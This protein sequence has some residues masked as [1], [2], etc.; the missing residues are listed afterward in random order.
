[1]CL[2][3][4]TAGTGGVAQ[5]VDHLP[6]KSKVLSSNPSNSVDVLSL[7]TSWFDLENPPKSDLN[8]ISWPYPTHSKLPHWI[9]HI[10]LNLEAPSVTLW[11]FF[12]PLE[13]LP[14]FTLPTRELL[15]TLQ[16]PVP[17]P[18]PQGLSRSFLVK[19]ISSARQPQQVVSLSRITYTTLNCNASIYLPTSW[20]MKLI[21]NIY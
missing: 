9:Y 21:I 1:V 3:N 6:S 5:M 2:N 20:Q 8:S 11:V 14:L 15:L 18:P 4:S 13:Y 10:P 17:T 16:C 19:L 12:L 7:P